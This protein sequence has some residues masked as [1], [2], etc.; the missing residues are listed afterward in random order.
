MVEEMRDQNHLKNIMTEYRKHGLRIAIDDFGAGHSGL[1]L[2]SIFQPD[3]IKIDRKLIENIDER[4][5]S[6]SIVRS[7]VQVCADLEIAVIAE[8]IE[9]EAERNVLADFGIRLMQGYYFAPPAFESLPLWP[10]APM[11]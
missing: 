7:I 3:I 2:L 10:S 4:P 5:V 8:G 6:R 1:S 9:R 11:S